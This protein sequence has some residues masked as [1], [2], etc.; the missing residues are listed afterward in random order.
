M[1]KNLKD[2]PKT[3]NTP[4]LK[5]QSEQA[6]TCQSN[7][8][9]ISTMVTSPATQLMMAHKTLHTSYPSMHPCY[10]QMIHQLLQIFL[11]LVWFK[12]GSY[13]F[14]TAFPPQTCPIF[15][16]LFVYH[17][18]SDCL[19]TYEGRNPSSSQTFHPFPDNSITEHHQ[20]MSGTSTVHS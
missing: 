10:C 11:S 5:S 6:S 4:T 1:T 12:P 16:L 9:S 13:H 2:T 14:Q 7:G 17:L 15:F 18:Y 3:C 20:V 8:S 19:A